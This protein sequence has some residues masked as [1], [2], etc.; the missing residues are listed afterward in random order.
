M[1]NNKTHPSHTEY[2]RYFFEV[3][4]TKIYFLDCK[5][6]SGRT[7]SVS[8]GQLMVSERGLY[9]EVLAKDDEGVDL[10]EM[11]F[12]NDF[13]FLKKSFSFVLLCIVL[14]SRMHNGH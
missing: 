7:I 8:I 1:Y 4:L 9:V 6:A 11:F 2:K 14:L 5:G 12:A 13:C 10:F 3:N